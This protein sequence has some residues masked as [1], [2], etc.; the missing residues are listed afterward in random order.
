MHPWKHSPGDK[1]ATAGPAEVKLQ[2]GDVV[3]FKGGVQYHGEIQITA[4]GSEGSP[5]VYDG[6]T[7]GGFGE[8]KAILDGAKMVEDWKPVESAEA[9]GGNPNWQQIMVAD[10]DMDLSSNF[11]QNAFILHRD[12]NADRQAPWQR[13]F[14]V[15]GERRVLPIAQTPKPSDPFF[16]DLPEDFYKTDNKIQSTYPHE[17][18]Y[19]EGSRGNNSLPIMGIVSPGG[20]PVIQPFNGGQVGIDLGEP[21][22]I[23]AFAFKLWRPETVPAPEQIAL[24][25]DGEEVHVAD[26]QMDTADM[27]RFEL[28]SPQRGREAD[29]RVASLRRR[30]QGVDEAGPSRRF[31]CRW[32]ERARSRRCRGGHQRPAAA[33]TR[34]SE[35]LRRRL[36]RRPWRQQPRVLRAGDSV[37]PRLP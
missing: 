20:A 24:F 36:H 33:D 23:K 18:Y 21:V 27:Q 25:I 31:R 34:R 29:F 13:L 3:I 6:N 15:D 32:E 26:V 1:N 4:S 37:R 14:L 5:I 2:P 16:P 11:N 28:P 17:L 7:D 30:H 10:L 8:G 19:P 35:P 22:E 12:G 9:V